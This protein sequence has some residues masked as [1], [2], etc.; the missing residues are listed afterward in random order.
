[1]PHTKLKI[2]AWTQLTGFSFY[3]FSTLPNHKSQTGAIEP[4]VL[5]F[6]SPKVIIAYTLAYASRI[7]SV[8]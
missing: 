6:L 8:E 1:M 7:Y 3:S 5:Y 4:R 2:N